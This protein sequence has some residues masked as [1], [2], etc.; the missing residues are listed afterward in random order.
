MVHCLFQLLLLITKLSAAANTNIQNHSDLP[1]DDYSMA[2]LFIPG[3]DMKQWTANA[4]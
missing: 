3:G 4:M 2:T 1:I